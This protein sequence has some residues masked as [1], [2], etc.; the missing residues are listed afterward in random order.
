MNVG[1]GTRRLAILLGV[2]GAV[3]GALAGQTGARK[4]WNAR[5]SSTRFESLMSFPTMRKVAKAAKEHKGE[6]AGRVDYT[7]LA[8]VPSGYV[9]EFSPVKDDIFDQVERQ[10][11]EKSGSMVVSLNLDGIK[12]VTVDR[13]GTVQMIRLANGSPLQ[14]TESPSLGS[15]FE[16]LLY[17][18]VGFLL[19]WGVVRALAWVVAGFV[20]PHRQ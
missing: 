17:P 5:A 7:V 14:R 10:E 6:F 3:V 2:L 13:T 19:P 1:E 16:M 8:T 20:S 18:A 4:L 9:L 12:E 15:Y 11:M